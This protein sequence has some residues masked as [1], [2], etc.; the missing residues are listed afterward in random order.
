MK[1]KIS[2]L[3]TIFLFILILSSCG[4]ETK[5]IFEGLKLGATKD[6]VYKILGKPTSS[7]EDPEYGDIDYYSKVTFLGITGGMQVCYAT[8]FD[9]EHLN[10]KEGTVSQINWYN[11]K[12]LG[13]TTTEIEK[14]FKTI[15][16][17]YTDKYGEAESGY[18]ARLNHETYELEENRSDI[19]YEWKD[20]FLNYICLEIED[21][22]IILR[23]CD[24]TSI[25]EKLKD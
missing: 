4:K 10:K 5:S 15:I 6:D 12:N 21:N 20:T 16:D 19:V 23:L 25:F 22:K 11:S 3:M 9:E 2:I 14:E 13:K 17:F 8:K 7:E 1:K 24:D 18:G